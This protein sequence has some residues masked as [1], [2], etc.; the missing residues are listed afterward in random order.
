MVLIRRYEPRDARDTWRVFTAAVRGTAVRDYCEAAVSVW[1][2]DDVDEER[3]AARRAAAHTFVACDGER[4]VGFS[5]LADD[6]LLDMLF[7]HPDHSSRGVARDLVAAVLSQARVLG[8][9][10]VE[11]HA[12]LTAR[13]VFERLGFVVDRFNAENWVRGHNLP[14]YDMHID[15]DGPRDE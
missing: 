6:G 10:R 15:L 3:W 1:A 12:S 2:P 8:V 11:T 14:N 7:V 5:D 9:T 13:P 4:V